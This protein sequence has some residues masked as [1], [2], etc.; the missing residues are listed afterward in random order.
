MSKV[1][2]GILFCQP[3]GRCT[4]PSGFLGVRKNLLQAQGLNLCS[5]IRRPIP[6]VTVLIGP[7]LAIYHV[8]L[9]VCRSQLYRFFQCCQLKSV[10]EFCDNPIGCHRC[11]RVLALWW[12]VVK[13]RHTNR[14][15]KLVELYTRGNSPKATSRPLVIQLSLAARLVYH[16]Q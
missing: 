8:G 16:Q 1:V 2:L 11:T 6:Y 10:S 5:T 4:D 12:L 15:S 13:M 9:D 14:T 3:T 7:K